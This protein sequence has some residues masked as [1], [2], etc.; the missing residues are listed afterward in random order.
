MKVIALLTTALLLTSGAAFAEG[1]SY[2]KMRETV[3]D[4]PLLPLPTEEPTADS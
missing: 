3:A 2:G 1:C 4:A